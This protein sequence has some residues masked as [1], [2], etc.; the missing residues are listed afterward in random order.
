MTNT[1]T[2]LPLVKIGSYICNSNIL[3]KRTHTFEKLHISPYFHTFTQFN[4]YIPLSFLM[5][6][7]FDT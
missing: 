6:Y 4:T 7:N 1:L 2:L 3:H 5:C